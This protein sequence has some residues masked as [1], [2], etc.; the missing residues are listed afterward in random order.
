MSIRSWLRAILP[1]ALA[2]GLLAGLAGP[3]AA[4]DTLALTTPY[5]AVAVA[6]G[7]KV[8][9][10]LTVKT[11]VAARVDLAV[12]GVPSDWTA[13]LHGGGFVV[14]ATQTNGT[15]PTTVRLDV[16]VP[17]SA[18]G[19]ASM[20]VTA[21]GLAQS[22][23]LPLD[24]KVEASAAGDVTITTDFPAL[25]GASD[26]TF[27]FN[28]TLHNDTP[29]DLTFAVT[30]QG[31]TGWTVDASLAGQAQAA[32]AIVKSGS[33]SGVTVSAK[34]PAGVA[35]GEYEIQ[36]A[37]TAGSKQISQNLAVKITGSFDL[38]LSTPTQVLNT[39]GSAGSVTEQ[40][41]T[42]TNN[43]TADLTNVQMTGTGPTNWKFEF[44]QPTIGSVTAG[45]EVI[46]TAKVTPAGDAIAGDYAVTFNATAEQASA[47]QD[48]RFTVQTSLV[49]AI[50][51]AALIVGVA[52]GLWWV[53]QR[54]GRR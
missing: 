20:V 5:P 36:V 43:G 14:S 15:D 25:E 1:A 27:N 31:P 39:S 37:G 12:S 3:A 11:S 35:A 32:S 21:T 17:S 4:V 18:T 33:T 54:Y 13:V 53:F 22:V 40:Q 38:S 9:F 19:S 16:T 52:A 10:D 51:G 42:V 7:S 48:I 46:I 34:P 2:I 28:L 24:V 50:I 44:D 23:A 41:L 8:S 6:P 26:A 30:G 29:E 49:W 47:S 45:Q